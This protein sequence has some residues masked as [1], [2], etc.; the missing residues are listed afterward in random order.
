M[1]AEVLLIGHSEKYWQEMEEIL[2]KFGGLTILKHSNMDEIMDLANDSNLN[3][4]IALLESKDNTVATN[5]W[6]QAI[7]MSFPHVPLLVIYSSKDHIEV[8]EVKKSGAS[9]L[10]QRPYDD[11]FIVDAMLEIATFEFD[12]NIPVAALE[13]IRLNDFK[14]ETVIDFDLF[15]HLP[16]NQKTICI[17]KKGTTIDEAVLSRIR[18]S[19]GQQLYVKKMDL[20]FFYTYASKILKGAGAS[21]TVSMTEK[22]IKLRTKI[23]NFMSVFLDSEEKSF[24]EGKALTEQFDEVI[25]ELE[26]LDFQEPEDI[27]LT[28]TAL[29]EKPKTNYNTAINVAVYAT[30][31]AKISGY[32]NENMKIITL[33]GLL[34]NIGIARLPIHIAKTPLEQLSPED[35][36]QYKKYPIYGINLVKS[37]KVPIDPEIVKVIEQHQ[38]RNDGSGFPKALKAQTLLEEAKIIALAIRFDELTSLRDGKEAFKPERALNMMFTEND[39][40]KNCTPSLDFTKIRKIKEFF[41]KQ[42]QKLLEAS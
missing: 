1:S 2:A 25:D 4:L 16:S 28:I 38:E 9:K 29:T 21:S 5:E 31:F 13:S 12:K 20:P 24:D 36:E 27:F 40:L 8:S 7:K 19:S 6:V 34:H 41:E 11:E 14:A 22:S 42:S 18:K 39:P 33:S 26:V 10:V 23:Q 32:K 15:T 35:Q 37:K 30:L 3:P 17:R